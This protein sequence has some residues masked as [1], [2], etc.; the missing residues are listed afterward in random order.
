MKYK[1]SVFNVEIPFGEK[2]ILYNTYSGALSLLDQPLEAAA[3]TIGS[4]A[5]AEQGFLVD[6]RIDEVNRLVME[7][8]RELYT[9]RIRHLHIEVAPTMKCQARCWYCFENDLAEKQSMSPEV[10]K[11]TIAFIKKQIDKTQCEEMVLLFFGGEPLLAS[12]QILLIGSEIWAYCKGKGVRFHSEVISN[13]IAFTPEL[14]DR[15][16]PG[17]NLMQLQ[18]TLDGLQ[19]TH[20]SAKGIPCFERVIE[21]VAANAGKTNISIRI[22]VSEKNS[23]E[24]PALI[25]YLLSE[26]QLDGKVRLYLAR[27]DDLDSCKI[28]ED[29]CL[30]NY[31]F[32]DFRN[33]LIKTCIKK[34]K[35]FYLSDL[36]PDIK[37][38]YCGYEKISQ[39]MIGPCG[40]LYRCQRTMGSASNSIGDIYTGSYYSDKELTLFRPLDAQCLQCSLLPTCFGGCPNERRKGKAITYCSLKREQI[41]KDLI[42]YVQAITSD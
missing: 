13:G 31:S 32:V 20:D 8:N 35:S 4:D 2:S 33:E 25:D 38:N 1:S 16:I 15:M 42:A 39:L 41:E 14:A 40:E 30:D 6:A 11:D 5:L 29:G 36:L 18:I 28:P 17:I 24:V 26:K 19:P 3:E 7:R 12:E 23:H 22:N 27:V 37:R 34:Y 10:T 21:N 9:Q